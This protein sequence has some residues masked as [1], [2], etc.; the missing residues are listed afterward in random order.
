[1][2]SSP[3]RIAPRV[4]CDSWCDRRIEAFLERVAVRGKRLLEPGCNE[5]VL[6]CRLCAAG[7]DV[8]A[9]DCR[10][11]LAVKAFARCLAHGHRTTVLVSDAERIGALGGFDVVFHSGLLYHLA[12]PVTHLRQLA[13]VAPTIFLSTQHHLP[14]PDSLDGYSGWRSDREMGWQDDMSAGA[15]TSFW[16][17]LESLYRVFDEIGFA[18]ETIDDDTDLPPDSPRASFLLTK[19]S[20]PCTLLLPPPNRSHI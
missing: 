3:W 2:F 4:D 14:S 20:L 15:G 8:T 6:T 19:K 7:A 5:G 16:L 18:C 9:F 10:P 12:D 1:M 13:E 17:S 11:R